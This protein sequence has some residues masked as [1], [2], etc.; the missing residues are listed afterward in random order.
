MTFSQF[1]ASAPAASAR[2]AHIEFRGTQGTLY[3]FG[4]GYEVVPDSLSP[5]EFPVQGPL[6]GTAGRSWR[7]GAKPAIV[8]RKSANRE[9]GDGQS[10]TSAHARN[11][12][13]CIRS[14]R[15][16]VWDIEVGHRDTS[17]A[18][19]GNIAYKLKAHLEWDG[20]AE[21]FTNYADANRLL[22]YTYRAPY[23]LPT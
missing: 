7:S 6:A 10:A 8:P 18:L 17:A 14:R 21:R 2:P 19:I 20:K 15:P 16:C 1:N 22:T 4:N 13:D 23:R 5:H 3:L 11:F 9:H 12:L